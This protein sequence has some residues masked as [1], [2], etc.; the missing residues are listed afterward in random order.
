MDNKQFR[1]K[2]IRSQIRRL[3]PVVFLML[4]IVLMAMWRTQNSVVVSVRD[5]A[6]EKMAPL[7]SFL[8]VPARWVKSTKK[9]FSD[10]VFLYQRNKDLERENQILRS[11]RALALQLQA[12]QDAVKKMAKYVPYPKSKSVS[13]RVAMDTGDKFSRSYIALAGYKDGIKNGSVAMTDTGILGR[14]IEVG[15]HASRLMLL[16]DY[17]SR[18]PVLVGAGRIPAILTGDNTNHPKLIFSDRLNEIKKGDVILTS[19]YMG[20]YPSGL[21]VGIVLEADEE[22]IEVELFETGENLEFVHLVDF[23]LGDVLLTKDCEE[24]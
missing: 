1:L 15:K 13:A 23:G 16:T 21:G 22:D 3:V 7:I 19:G 8:S 11:W 18:V 12:E 14:V 24:P 20:V 4:A 5:V 17:L 10:V 2:R 9:T 6:S